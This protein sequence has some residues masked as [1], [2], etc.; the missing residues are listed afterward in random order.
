MS[1]I[2]L[3]AIERKIKETKEQIAAFQALE[4]SEMAQIQALELERRLQELLNEKV[5]IENAQ[6]KELVLLRAYGDT[7]ETGRISNRLLISML[8]GF[9]TMIDN[10]ANVMVG[11]RAAR[12]QIEDY[13]RKIADFEVC[14][15]FEGSFG[16]KLEKNYGQTELTH[17]SLET[18]NVL[19][20]F[21]SILENSAD[22][23]RLIEKISPYGQRTVKQY[24]AW[25]KQMKDNAVNVELD[26]TSEIAEKRKM[27]LKFAHADDII[28][29]LD[30][31]SSIHD[32]DVEL[33]VVVTG[34][35]IRKNTFEIRT[36][37]NV[38]IK[39][40]SRLETLI[41]ASEYL[42][43]NVRAN[44]VKSVSESSVCGERET[45]FLSDLAT[46]ITSDE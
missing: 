11:T 22:S 35:N 23:E 31:I 2:S 16:V 20:E 17:Q 24:R 34:V 38:I 15:V 44:L 18:D 19:Q 26:W 6:A 33:Q 21:F 30:S 41:K 7:I 9:Q 10:I 43:K 42:G 3:Y 25:L 13:A 12:G 45:W 8:D 4:S 46:I 37:E 29:T 5:D 36:E 40:K 1:T 39:G 14:G 28:Y 32:E 27:D